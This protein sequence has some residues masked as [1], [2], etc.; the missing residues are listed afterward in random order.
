M[1]LETNYDEHERPKTVLLSYDEYQALLAKPDECVIVRQTAN[2][3]IELIQQFLQGE[4]ASATADEPAVQEPPPDD[5]VIPPELLYYK[6]ATGYYDC[7]SDKFLVLKGSKARGNPSPTFS[8]KK[9]DV[10]WRNWMIKRGILVRENDWEDYI[11]TQDYPFRSLSFAA[12][13]I[14]GN[15]RSGA[16]WVKRGE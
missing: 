2:K 14:D 3:I 12:C 9:S 8:D 11:F 5:E 13:L 15:S 6:Q 4:E 7:D 1:P 10:F 16:V